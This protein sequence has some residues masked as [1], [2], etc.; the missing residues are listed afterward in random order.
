MMWCGLLNRK[1]KQMSQ[2]R[3]LADVV[4]SSGLILPTGSVLQ[5]VTNATTCSVSSLTNTSAADL[6]NFSLTITPSSTSSKI[7]IQASAM[8][9]NALVGSTNVTASLVLVRDST[10]L[11]T[12]SNSA[13]SSS[14]GIQIRD[15]VSFVDLDSPSTTSAVTYKVQGKTNNASSSYSV[16][17]GEI[18]AMEIAG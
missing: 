8:V 2:A 16:L 9:S 12:H 10:T 13:Q 15:S 14:G 3:N 7:L 17:S 11:A 4:G 6:S 1:D 5:T 18:V